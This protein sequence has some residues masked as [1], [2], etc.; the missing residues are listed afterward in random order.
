M[1]P[2]SNISAH[3]TCIIS[4]RIPNCKGIMQRTTFVICFLFQAIAL[5]VQMP[6]YMVLFAILILLLYFCWIFEMQLVIFL[7]LN[8][9]QIIEVVAT[10]ELTYIL[11]KLNSQYT[12]SIPRVAVKLLFVLCNNHYFPTPSGVKCIE[13]CRRPWSCLRHRQ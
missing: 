12:G 2:N 7:S 4:C 5:Y 1:S 13:N 10:W 8:F 9:Y 3:K 6:N 11:P